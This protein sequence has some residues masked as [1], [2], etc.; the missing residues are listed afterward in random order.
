MTIRYRF[1]EKVGARV[2][3]KAKS[4]LF[5]NILQQEVGFFDQ[6]KSGLFLC[7]FL[8]ISFG[9]VFFGYFTVINLSSFY[10]CLA[11]LLHIST[12]EILRRLGAFSSEMETI[13]S[14][15]ERTIT[16]VLEL[17]MI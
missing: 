7:F 17:G 6:T 8:L 15:M 5:R 13:W 3:L 16:T 12:G 2:S 14:L 4:E 10:T 11:I 9:N 1:A